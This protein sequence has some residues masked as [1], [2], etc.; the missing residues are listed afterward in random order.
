M[1]KLLDFIAQNGRLPGV[2]L[3]ITPL[4]PSKDKILLDQFL[5]YTFQ[6]SIL[7]PVD[8]FN[9][10]FTMPQTNLSLRDFI[11]EGDLVELTAAGKTTCTGI[12]DV[13]DIETTS[14]GGDVV[15]VL[16]RNLLS[17]VEDQS[18]V[19]DQELPIY[20]KNCTLA[21][22]VGAVI[23]KTRIRPPLVK[24]NPIDGN[25]LFATEPG[26]SKLSA[27]QRFVEPLNCLIWANP[28][29]N[30][31]VGRPN[32]GQD[33]SGTLYCDK[34][35]R[36][37]NVLSIKAT[38][39][40]TQIPNKVV[41]IWSG[42]E[43]VVSRVSAQQGIPNSAE[44][45]NTLRNRGHLVTKAIVVSTPSGSDPQS[46]SD[47]NAIKVAGSN[48][49]QAYALRE[50]AKANINELI[51]QVNVK[52]HF[53]DDL[54]PFLI[55]QVYYINYPRGGVEEKMYLYQV[56]YSL[57]AANGARTT[58]HFCKLGCIV[59]GASIAAATKILEKALPSA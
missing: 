23:N 44:G 54:Q 16:G 37:S 3:S 27:L 10:T 5:A 26:E 50:I 8:A 59:A 46:V 14:E 39:A 32:F 21:N 24:Q 12:I 9:F 56:E 48:L 13:T 42:Q 41:P 19:N 45:P 52:G 17:Q 20:I 35:N 7:I 1:S 49:L 34:Q 18:C 55:D 51:V 31:V 43:S 11:R 15:S 2:G 36:R 25:F 57:D 38:R 47:I 29:G 33:S 22:A 6:S 30:M 40:N 53:N 28:I 58:L 4:D